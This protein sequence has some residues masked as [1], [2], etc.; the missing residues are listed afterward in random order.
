MRRLANPN[1]CPN[2]WQPAPDAYRCARCGLLLAGPEPQ[3]LHALLS[4]ADQLLDRLRAEAAAW[5]R[6][7]AGT[8]PAT[9]LAP[10]AGAP[11]PHRQPVRS[12]TSWSVGSILLALGALC[13]AVAAVVFVGVSWSALGPSGRTAAL[14]VVTMAAGAVAAGVTRRGLRASAEAL[15]GVTIVMFALDYAGARSYG[16]LGLDRMGAEVSAL[17]LGSALFAGGIAVV[18]FARRRLDT[19]LLSGQAGVGVGLTLATSAVVLLLPVDIFW[20]AAACVVPVLAVAVVLHRI[21]LRAVAWYA[22]GLAGAGYVATS[23]AALGHAF[24]YPTVSALLEQQVALRTVAAASMTVVIGAV[25]HRGARV[26]VGAAPARHTATATTAVAIGQ[27][28]VLAY[29]PAADEPVSAQL[30]I[31]AVAVLLAFAGFAARGTWLRGVR[32]AALAATV[33]LVVVTA[34]WLAVAALSLARSTTPVWSAGG[35]A[36]VRPFDGG[37]GPAWLATVAFSA[38]AVTVATEALWRGG[39]RPRGRAPLLAVA[40]VLI[41]AGAVIQ[42][43][44]RPVPVVVVAATI[45]V[46]GTALAV[47]ALGRVRQLTGLGLVL[48]ATPVALVSQVSSLAV[49][50]AAAAIAAFLAA[51]TAS[52]LVRGVAT[53]AAIGST[54]LAVAGWVDLAGAD[55]ELVQLSV[56][57]VA[58]LVLIAAQ[59][60]SVAAAARTPAECVAGGF[61]GA[62]LVGGVL[63]PLG[64]QSGMY[65]V[66]GAACVAVSLARSDRRLVGTAGA[67]LLGVGYVL[68]LVAS[69]VGTV[70]AYTLPLGLVLL[71]GGY[72]AMRRRPELA[73]WT[74]LLPGLSLSMLPTLPFVLVDPVTVR[75][76]LLGAGALTALGVGAHRRWQAPFVFGAAVLAAVVVHHVGPYAQAVPRWSLIGTT[77]IAML[78][79]GVR[80]EA[81][82]R[83]AHAVTT[84]VRSMR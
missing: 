84:Y 3:R 8:A 35:W 74:A 29:A 41:G 47:P 34:E 60:R 12:R 25:A 80:W 23:L 18:R 51:A 13:L 77:G 48:A 33:P 59:L 50:T 28:T 78:A 73:T 38:L 65:T 75:G 40:F 27:L 45:V 4:E 32:V 79:V 82:V 5:Q 21:G 31:A 72:V 14:G 39:P 68:R 19:A 70:E 67:V 15:W 69:G 61:A 6:A 26:R 42:L 44:I 2:C 17:V 54:H 22:A 20:S 43:C 1:S 30:T 24:A 52:S 62:A 37:L 81:R 11:V 10:P 57:L 49:W 36:P 53:V 9:G 76:L 55:A 56:L 71:G 66:A 83:D 7:A 58:A 16:L 64:W 63:L 46:I